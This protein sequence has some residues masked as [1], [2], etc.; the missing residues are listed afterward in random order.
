MI[1]QIQN[2]CYRKKLGSFKKKK[3]GIYKNQLIDPVNSRFTF[4]ISV[5]SSIHFRGDIH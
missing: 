4:K 1:Y 3:K 5:M 2:W